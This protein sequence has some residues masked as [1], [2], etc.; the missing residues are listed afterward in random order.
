MILNVSTST[1]ERRMR[2]YD[3]SIRGTYSSIPDSAL[4][5]LVTDLSLQFPN[6]GYRMISGF[7]K[8]SGHRVQERRV[9]ES[10]TRVDPLSLA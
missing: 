4:D 1:I 7:L 6:V 8:A 5:D 2:L 3:L 9:R 10:L